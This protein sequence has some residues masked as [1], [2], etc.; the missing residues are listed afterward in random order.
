MDCEDKA[1]AG[2]AKDRAIR[3]ASLILLALKCVA[4]VTL[5]VFLWRASVDLHRFS[6]ASTTA[7]QK[8]GDAADDLGSAAWDAANIAENLEKDIADLSDAL[9]G[10]SDRVTT[11]LDRVFIVA[12]GAAGELEKASKAMRTT[13]ELQSKFLNERIPAMLDKLDK[14]LDNITGISNQFNRETLPAFTG[15]LTS[16]KTNITDNPELAASIGNLNRILGSGA[17]IAEDGYTVEH[18]YFFPPKQAGVRKFL[19]GAWF[20]VREGTPISYYLRAQ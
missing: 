10:D 17:K 9:V 14:T 15:L 3:L 11:R 1:F 16:A 6:L 8:L 12:G 2:V 13:A 20:V 19:G 7:M 5:V 18:K 4:S